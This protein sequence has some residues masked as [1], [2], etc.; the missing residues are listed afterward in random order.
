MN[1]LTDPQQGEPREIVAGDK[2]AWRRDDLTADYAS[3]NGWA[4]AYLFVWVAGVTVTVT[5]TADAQGWKALA[6]AATYAVGQADWFLQATHV[7]YGKTT[8]DRGTVTVLANPASAGAG[9]D[10]RS[11]AKKVLDAIEAAIEA[12]ASQT[13]LKTVLE[14]GRSIERLS[15]AQLLEMRDAYAAKVRREERVA[16]GRGPGRVLVSM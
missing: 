11:H 7:T 1:P 5:M 9:Y 14:D 12:R 4:L 10:P 8:V 16:R 2:S 6:D 15:H 3:A 13:D